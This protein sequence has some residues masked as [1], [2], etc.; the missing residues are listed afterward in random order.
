MIVLTVLTA[1]IVGIVCLI[2]ATR[3]YFTWGNIS[4][5]ALIIFGICVIS[6]VSTIIHLKNISNEKVWEETWTTNIVAL[7]D[8]SG[9]EG[10]LDGSI[11]IVSG[12]INETPY[13]YC[14]ESTSEGKHMI[15]IPSDNAYIVE[16]D[17]KEPSIIKMTQKYID[18]RYPFWIPTTE[19]TKYIIY[20]PKGTV[21]TTYRIDLE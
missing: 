10:R 4:K 8:N 9:V 13:Y 17:E 6:I 7:K 16:T 14:M 5:I 1:F 12:Q 19:N 11:F 3:E 2:Y 21:D 18:K 20:V 15:K